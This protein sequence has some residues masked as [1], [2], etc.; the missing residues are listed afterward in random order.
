MSSTFLFG[1]KTCGI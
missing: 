1:K